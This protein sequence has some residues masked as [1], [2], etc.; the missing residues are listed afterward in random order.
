[1]GDHVNVLADDGV[2]RALVVVAHSDDA[3]FWAGGTVAC[4]SAAGI[5]VTYVALSTSGAGWW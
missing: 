3:E 1:M 5:A 4:W 2:E